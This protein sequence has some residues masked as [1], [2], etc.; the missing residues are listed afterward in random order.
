MRTRCSHSLVSVASEIIRAGLTAAVVAALGVGACAGRRYP[1]TP[2][3][4]AAN[5]ETT[6]RAVSAQPQIDIL[7]FDNQ[8]TAYVDVYLVGGQLQWRLGRV[9]P[10]MRTSLRVPES[11]VDWA[12]TTVQLAVIPGSQMSAQV[13]RDPRATVA[14]AQTLSE[15]LSQ[16]WIFRQPDGAPIQLLATR[17]PRR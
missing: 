5:A 6:A 4:R 11:V 12:T 13:S 9:L 2:A 16:L 14:P 17:L 15:L 7:Q 10:G 1:V 3:Q 8:A